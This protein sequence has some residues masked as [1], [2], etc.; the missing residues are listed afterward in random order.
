[1]NKLS[2]NNPENPLILKILILT[3]VNVGF[4]YLNPTYSSTSNQTGEISSTCPL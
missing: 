2:I 1:M 3:I 4:P